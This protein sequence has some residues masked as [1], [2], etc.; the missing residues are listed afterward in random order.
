MQ[1]VDRSESRNGVSPDRA[2]L[3]SLTLP[4]HRERLIAI[5]TEY[6]TPVYLYDEAGIRASAR[7]LID[8]FSWVKDGRG[9]GFKNFFAVKATPNPAILGILREE[10]LGADCSSLPELMLAERSGIVG[11][12]IMFTSNNT[13]AEEFVAARRLGGIINLDDISHISFLERHAGIPPVI[14][15]RYNPGPLR[16]GNVIIG[17]P[18]E[19]KYGLTR[20]Q[21]FDAYEIMKGKGVRRFGLHTMV[22]SNELDPQYF[23]ETAKMLFELVG[24]LS[25]RGI[26]MEFVNLGGGIGIPYKPEQEPVDVEAI[27]AGVKE[28]YDELIV[29]RDLDPLGITMEC[30]RYITGPHGFLVAKA[31]HKKDIYRKYVGVDASMANLMRPGMY[32]AYH[33]ITIP[34][35]ERAPRDRTYDVTGGL[36]ENNDKFGVQRD[37]PEIQIG[38][39]VV[40]HDAGAHGH[41]MGFNYNG[42]LRSAEVLLRPDGSTQ[43]IRRAET[44]ADHF[45]TLVFDGAQ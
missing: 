27:S 17:N 8:A 43:L 1:R 6:P 40:I 10:G 29:A 20:E 23:V 22:A 31:I 14:S 18:E 35:K 39:F 7:R 41:S 5:T 36:C 19:A 33:H 2:T 15:F 44:I 25:E 12:D 26:N 21:I 37:L 34:G 30:G 11:E 3:K 13:P 24:D 4:F 32:G 42:K 28:A 9:G 38:D 45:T 16:E